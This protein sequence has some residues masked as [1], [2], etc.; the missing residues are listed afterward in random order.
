MIE[1]LGFPYYVLTMRFNV[2][3]EKALEALVYVTSKVPG[4]TRFHVSKIMYFAERFHIH[5]F[6]RPIVGDSYIA[7]E[8]GPVPSF[9]Y[10]IL[11]NKLSSDE[12]Q[13]ADGA[14]IFIDAYRHPEYKAARS[15]RLEFFSKSDLEC[16]D[17]AIAHCSGR[18]FGS[19]SDE[20]HSHSAW[21]ET[22]LN[23]RIDWELILEGAEPSTFDEAQVFSSYGVL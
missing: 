11:T 9:A 3:K 12:A 8:H 5:D 22:D 13:M 16:L 20:T 1:F 23:A 7:M 4:I 15:P 18:T 14:L 21:K 6:G 10:N 19:I 2:D 17:R